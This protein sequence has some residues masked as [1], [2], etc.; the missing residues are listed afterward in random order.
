MVPY[1]GTDPVERL[2]ARVTL[3]FFDRYVLGQ[4]SAR[5][6]MIRYGNVP[7]RSALVFG[8]RPPP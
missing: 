6:L 3:A 8:G 2:A 1:I 7:G 4:A 5:A